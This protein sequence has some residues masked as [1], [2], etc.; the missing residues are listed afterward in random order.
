MEIVYK[1]QESRE[2]PLEIDITSSQKTVYVR[3]NIKEVEVEDISGEK[4]K[5]YTYQE[6]KLTKDLYEQY[7]KDLLVDKINGSDNS[8]AFENYKAKLDTPVEYSNGHLYKPKWA[9]SV[10]AGLLTKGSLLPSLFP[11]KIW[12]STELEE[13]AVEMTMQELTALT[14]FLGAKQEQYFAEYKLEKAN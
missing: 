13:N 3:R 6:A 8:Q 7:S 4:F 9:E 2:K 11:L 14:L 1:E 10:Y 12:D 5:K